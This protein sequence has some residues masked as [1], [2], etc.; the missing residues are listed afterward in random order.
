[1]FPRLCWVR[2]PMVKAFPPDDYEIRYEGNGYGECVI[3]N[4]PFEVTINSSAH[5]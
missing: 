5:P 4:G 2:C 3:Q 1:M